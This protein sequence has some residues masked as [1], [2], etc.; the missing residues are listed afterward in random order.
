MRRN[1]SRQRRLVAT[2][3]L[4]AAAVLAA[5]TS[6]AACRHHMHPGPEDEAVD[7][8]VSAFMKS[9]D[10][11]QVLDLLGLTRGASTDFD[12]SNAPEAIPCDPTPDLLTVDV[13]GRTFTEASHFEWHDCAGPGYR[14]PGNVGTSSGTIDTTLAIGSDV[15]SSCDASS[16]YP[17]DDEASYA[18]VRH[19]RDGASLVASGDASSTT[20]RSLDAEV[21]TR[22]T[23]LDAQR[24]L[25]KS[26]GT[27]ERSVHLLGDILVRFDTETEPEKR[28]FNGTVTATYLDGSAET[29]T[30]TDVVR[31]PPA[32]CSE[33]V[34]GVVQRLGGDGI[35]H[36]LVFG[37]DCGDETLDGQPV[38]RRGM[39]GHRAEGTRQ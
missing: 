23:H 27:I 24:V 18:I 7:D 34:A 22:L 39:F 35:T 32:S 38:G 5:T 2:R 12:V 11:V 29:V 21:F 14:G 20:L 1:V 10:V 26:D 31:Y 4:V 30:L 25:S 16:E 13:C 33:P 9:V 17:F 3:V 15:S 28:T 37:P 36:T 19:L 8:P 6:L